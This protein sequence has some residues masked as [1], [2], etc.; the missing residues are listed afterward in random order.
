[1]RNGDT[2]VIRFRFKYGAELIEK[3]E[4]FMIREGTPMAFG[5]VKQVYSMNENIRDI[6]F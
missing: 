3:G 1:M 5:Q 4:K 6:E 2:G